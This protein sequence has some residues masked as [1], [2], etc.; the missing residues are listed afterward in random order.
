MT[1]PQKTAAAVG[2]FP[3]A[4]LISFKLLS[5]YWG[6]WLTFFPLSKIVGW[7]YYDIGWCPAWLVDFNNHAHEVVTQVYF[8][9]E[10][11]LYL[12]FGCALGL[13]AF[14]CIFMALEELFPPPNVEKT[15]KAGMQYL[16]P[17]AFSRLVAK[18]NKKNKRFTPGF[19]IHPGQSGG[20]LGKS[21]GSIQ[22]SLDAEA[23]H[24]LSIGTTGAG[25]TAAI[26]ASF[27][28]Y[29]SRLK[30]GLCV[31]FDVKGD[32]TEAL[33][34][35]SNVTLMAPWD[36]RGLRWDISKE[37]QHPKDCEVLASALVFK[38]GATDKSG[39]GKDD[40]FVEQARLVF[41]SIMQ[42][43]F[44]DGKLT[45]TNLSAFTTNIDLLIGQEVDGEWAPGLLGRYESARPALDAIARGSDQTQA[46]WTTLQNS[47][48]KWV[49]DAAAAFGKDPDW[50]LSQWLQTPEN[51]VQ[52]L[53]IQFNETFENLSKAMASAM[54][55][56]TIKRVLQM[57]EGDNC[58]WLLMD[59]VANFPRIPNL[60][61]G[62]TLGRDRGLRCVVSTQDVTQLEQKYGEKDCKTI[63]NQCNNQIWLRANDHENAK[64][65]SESLGTHE[66]EV[67]SRG[68]QFQGQG[69]GI[70][71]NNDNSS[72]NYSLQRETVVNPGEI[73]GLRHSRDLKGGGAEGF[74]RVSGV[75]A[76]TQLHWPR[77][78]LKKI[79]QKEKLATWVFNHEKPVS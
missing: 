9:P 73:M 70:G 77:M 63:L 12:L 57:P 51:N 74:L 64:K 13:A 45:W 62:L 46:T 58:I 32:F 75:P 50:S 55:S 56:L 14:V 72:V 41:Q 19:K 34:E 33:A 15:H 24:F 11:R 7:L 16:R 20:I 37:I 52:F 79:F 60:K 30:N 28:N 42:C 61:R 44:N 76:I 5:G 40:F 8:W 38:T 25:K 49:R 48:G 17:K 6:G 43:L 18:L 69:Q 23:E 4:V 68:H 26:L 53:V 22:L 27:I 3:I 1:Y 71:V 35:Y 65:A 36:E 59:E 67:Q 10:P 78:P 54:A 31:I 29:I 47:V 39:G 2:A 66:V 21:F